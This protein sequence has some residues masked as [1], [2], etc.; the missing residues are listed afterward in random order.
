MQENQTTFAK[1]VNYSTF[2]A[3]LGGYQRFGWCG[4]DMPDDLPALKE[5]LQNLYTIIGGDLMDQHNLLTKFDAE[6]NLDQAATIAHTVKNGA[7]R[8]LTLTE[9]GDVVSGKIDRLEAS[10]KQGGAS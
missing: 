4:R 5:Y 3:L 1:P 8:I 7:D 10:A 6:Y 2:A 9:I